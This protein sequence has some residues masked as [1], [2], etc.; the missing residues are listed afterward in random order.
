MRKEKFHFIFLSLK[1]DRFDY[2]G[3]SM[4]QSLFPLLMKSSPYLHTEFI[5]IQIIQE[6]NGIL[7]FV[8]K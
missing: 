5:E 7:R 4:S 8:Y 3:E 2:F 1:T 6:I